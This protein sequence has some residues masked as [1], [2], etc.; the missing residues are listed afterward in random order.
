MF[1][2]SSAA[3]PGDCGPDLPA[4]GARRCRLPRP[5]Q[6]HRQGGGT[7]ADAEA[8]PGVRD[9]VRDAGLQQAGRHHGP[10]T[11]GPRTDPHAAGIMDQP[12]EDRE[13]ILT[14]PASWTSHVRTANRSSRCRRTYSS[15]ATSSASSTCWPRA[16][17]PV[18]HI[19]SRT[20][21]VCLSVCLSVT[22]TSRCLDTLQSGRMMCM[23]RRHLHM[24]FNIDFCHRQRI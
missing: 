7:R 6:R 4:S 13:Q 21:S 9:E 1:E 14:L 11:R 23:C 24:C 17:R 8:Q 19:V 12:R 16:L 3:D 18:I 15:C 5:A 10:A 20:L 2:D 22:S